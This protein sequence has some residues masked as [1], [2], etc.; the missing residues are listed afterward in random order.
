LRVR[1]SVNR[2]GR[3]DRASLVAFER[4]H[5]RP[6]KLQGGTLDATAG[7]IVRA[8][9]NFVTGRRTAWITLLG[10][11]VALGL[12]F[13]LVPQPTVSDTLAAGLPASSDSQRVAALLAR[14]PTANTAD[15]LIV[16]SR[17]DGHPL[18][19]ADRTAVDHQVP[20]LAALTTQ[21]QDVRAQVSVDRMATAAAVLVRQT[22]VDKDAGAV[23]S[24][25]LRAARVGLPDN[26]E[27]RL[28]GEIA[29]AADNQAA[30]AGTD[31]RL[32]LVLGILLA[33]LLILFTRS[34]VVWIVPLVVI[35]AADWLTRIVAGSVDAALGIP[36]SVAVSATLTVVVAAVG[37]GLSQLL[38]VR[39]R[40]VSRGMD[41]PHAAMRDVLGTLRGVIAASAATVAIGLL[42]LLLAAL[43]DTRA[44]GV[45]CAVGI[46]IVAIFVLTLLPAALVVFPRGAFWLPTPRFADPKA[47]AQDPQPRV[48]EMI[49]LRRSPL[50]IAA[51]VV[52]G[53]LALGLVGAQLGG[54]RL[55]ADRE[56]AEAHTIVDQAFGAGYGNNAIMLVPDSL[57][58]STAVVSPT[59]L[60]IDQNVVH[61]VIRGESH[62]GRT[63]LIV[64]LTADAG[65]P[66][67]VSTVRALRASIAKAGGSTARTLIG[68][69]DAAAIDTRDAASSDRGLVVPILA[70]LLLVMLMLLMRAVL[71][72]VILLAAS[73]AAFVGG[74]GLANLVSVQ[75]LGERT[76]DSSVVV[77]AFALVTAIGVGYSSV[78]VL[79]ARNGMRDAI[80][81]TGGQ[82]FGAGMMLSGAFVVLAV[83]IPVVAIEQLGWIVALGVLLDT[84]V[85][86]AFLVPALALIL[87]ERFSWPRRAVPVTAR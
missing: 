43:T 68:G 65:S 50:A 37:V 36:M 61:S 82:L 17:V 27:A 34:F 32:W 77:P 19:S 10:C 35:G 59:S 72:S 73:A 51:V 40:E 2:V 76:I 20:A 16:W 64:A 49:E 31:L 66:T 63:E 54:Q 71:G 47:T 24:G 33:V 38:I 5:S 57:R 41:D 28:T 84:L 42:A 52:I 80:S 86:R 12:V 9:T 15:G 18:T 4:P 83:T 62:G 53:L 8:I 81:T 23:E 87:G 75:L 13:A 22:A 74:L 26:L 11:L 48:A 85:A 14:F 21:P 3:A 44:L 70:G 39:Y 79:R 78:L 30:Y 1:C 25:L 45:A 7:G 58:G 67:A 46:V 6:Q 29:T 55:S 69:P 60:A 56:S